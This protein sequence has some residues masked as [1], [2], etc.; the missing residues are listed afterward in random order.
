VCRVNIRM[1]RMATC[2]TEKLVPSAVSSIPLL[3]ETAELRGLPRVL[4]FKTYPMSLITMRQ[5]FGQKVV[6]P[7]RKTPVKTTWKRSTFERFN[8]LQVFDTQNA[9]V[10][11]V[12]LLHRL[13]HET[14]DLHVGMFLTLRKVLD[15]AIARIAGRLP[16]R[17]YQ[18]VLVVGV[19]PDHLAHRLH[20]GPG[21]L[22]QAFDK[23]PPLA[24]AQAYRLR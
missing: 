15:G 24:P 22:H 14:L 18:P 23:E 20:S 13:P 17:E 1:V 10:R 9:D 11:K 12:D 8:V 19:H 6:Q 5:F 7:V 16:I 21:F 3:A 4:L 2:A